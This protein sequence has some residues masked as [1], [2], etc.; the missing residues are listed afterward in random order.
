MS[1][2]RKPLADLWFLTGGN[3]KKGWRQAIIRP[4]FPDKCIK[5][6]KIG[7]KVGVGGGDTFKI[8]LCRSATVKPN[9]QKGS[10]S[11]LCV[12]VTTDTMLKVNVDVDTAANVPCE[13]SFG[14]RN[15]Q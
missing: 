14:G 1:W 15:E 8:F 7:P 2:W 3:P 5:M 11:I 6:K 12:N 13:R 10:R 4:N 9:M